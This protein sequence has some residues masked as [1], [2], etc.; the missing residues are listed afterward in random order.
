MYSESVNIVLIVYTFSSH[1]QMTFKRLCFEVQKTMFRGPKGHV[2][3]V[4]RWSFEK[5]M[6]MTGKNIINKQYF[7]KMLFIMF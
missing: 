2:L 5:G 6:T 3:K 4:K 1:S 7:P